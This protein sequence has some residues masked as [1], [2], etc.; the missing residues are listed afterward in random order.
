MSIFVASRQIQILVRRLARF[1]DESV[2]EDHPALPV[3]IEKHPRDAVLRQV[4]PHLEE[5]IAQGLANRHPEGPAEF[6]RLDI[7]PDALSVFR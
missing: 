5:T 6:H 7:F 2:E 1:L 4:G 3:N